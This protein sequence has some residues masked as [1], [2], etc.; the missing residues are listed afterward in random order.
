MKLNYAMS[1]A[2]P[3][4]MRL[5]GR[6]QRGPVGPQLGKRVR[7]RLVEET[8]LP[9]AEVFRSFEEASKGRLEGCISDYSI[10]QTSLEEV[11]LHFSREAGV[12]E[13][14]E[15]AL[16]DV[17]D[18]SPPNKELV[19]KERH[20][21]APQFAEEPEEPLCAS[22]LL[23]DPASAEEP[24]VKER[25]EEEP[26]EPLCA[27]DL[28]DDPASVQEPFGLGPV[29]FGSA[30]TQADQSPAPRHLVPL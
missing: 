18:T 14:P 21:E 1:L 9:L 3:G 11:F 13:D 15:I 16:E 4:A 5:L 10:S 26:E 28:L 8:E 24:V 12:V 22:D 6:S 30:P 2:K 23:D 17:E 7:K 20:E 29:K 27:S 25:H 19:V